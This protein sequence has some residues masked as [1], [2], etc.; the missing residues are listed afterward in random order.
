MIE[1]SRTG[2]LWRVAKTRAALAVATAAACLL[3]AC[4]SSSASYPSRDAAVAKSLSDINQLLKRIGY[5]DPWRKTQKEGP[6]HETDDAHG[7]LVVSAGTINNLSQPEGAK[8]L[9]TALATWRTAGYSNVSENHASADDSQVTAQD[10]AY[11]L[12]LDVGSDGETGIFISS[13]YSTPGPATESVSQTTMPA[14]AAAV[15]PTPTASTS[16]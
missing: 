5:P 15:S 8:F 1:S 13:C 10:G 12:E 3:G 11:T 4:S 9:S 14:V 7:S 16:R 6:C 2:R